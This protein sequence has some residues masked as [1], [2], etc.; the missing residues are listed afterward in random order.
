MVKGVRQGFAIIQDGNLLLGIETHGDVGVAQGIG[1]AGGLD[2]VNDL[3]KLEGEVFRKGARFLPGENTS[4]I[5]FGG[6]G[7]MGIDNTSGF[8][9]K[10]LV[11]IGHEHGQIGVAIRHVGDAA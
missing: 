10:A 9:G 2:L 1:W 5:I 6:E 7:A 11:E 8:H 3:L 4:E